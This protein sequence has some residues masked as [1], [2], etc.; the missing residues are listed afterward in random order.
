MLSPLNIRSIAFILLFLNSLLCFSE[1]KDNNEVI[2]AIGFSLEPYAFKNGNGIMLDII[3]ESLKP[4]GK[5]THF[6]FYSNVNAVK[7]FTHYHSDAIAVVSKGM[8]SGYYSQPFITLHNYAISLK[9]KHLSLET[10]DD[11]K[12]HS[13]LA[14]SNARKYLGKEFAAV[15]QK[16][17]NYQEVEKQLDQI[18]ALFQGKTDIIIV[19]QQIFNFHLNRMRS[20]APLNNK[21]RQELDFHNL[22]PPSIYYAAFHN[23]QLRDDFNQGF[24]A[25][26]ASGETD[27]IY[28]LYSNLLRHYR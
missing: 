15:T 4:N 1:S 12:S 17:N 6:N 21:Y 3:R 25:L 24:N 16:I 13:L 18:E 19:D 8:V 5:M 27:K 11:L 28:Q 26:N 22:F 9:N 23:K 20:R 14:F 10:L 2:F 7:K